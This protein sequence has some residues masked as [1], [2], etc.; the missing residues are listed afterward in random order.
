MKLYLVQHA[1]SKRREEDPSRPLSEKRWSD[2]RKV[3]K[4]AEKHLDIEVSQIIY[5]GKLR[6]KQTTEVLAEYLQ[7]ACM[8]YHREYRRCYHY[9]KRQAKY[10]NSVLFHFHFS[11]KFGY[12]LFQRPYSALQKSLSFRSHF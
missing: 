8:R 12:L 2:I 11:F 10:F 9:K 6:A 3:A 5:S 7:P 1:E 4:Y